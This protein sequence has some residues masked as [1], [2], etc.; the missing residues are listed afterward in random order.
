MNA[1][2]IVNGAIRESGIDLDSLS[3][4]EW[5]TPTNPMHSKFKEW[6]NQAW[7]EIQMERLEWEFMSKTGSLTISPRLYVELGDRATAPPL[8]STF[9]T[10]ETEATFTITSTTL[11]D[12]TWLAGTA[13][14][15]IDYEELDGQFK[16][17]EYVNELTPT[18]GDSVFKIMGWGRYDLAV[19][20]PD[21]DE[22][23][24]GAF[25]IQSTGSSTTQ[26]N[27]NSFDLEQ[28]QLVPWSI[29]KDN[30][31]TMGS[32]GTPRLFTIVPNGSLD[33]FPRP[34]KQYFIKFDYSAVPQTFTDYDDSPDAL[35]TH[36]HEAIV[37]KAVVFYAQYERARDI[38]VR[39]DKRYRFYKRILD[40][41]KKPHFTFTR[42]RFNG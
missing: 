41:Q 8:N 7:K 1:L 34:E 3:S 35:P 6:V 40:R 38:E 2:E 20:Y 30:Y 36:L 26:E 22:S 14:A 10:E 18:A 16:F 19:A 42:N 9:V 5:T 32:T 39:A 12:G 23:N 15:Y 29:W 37:W 33:F 13:V 24:I 11:L 17:D 27:T 21:L 25:Y 28:L 31:E 4:S